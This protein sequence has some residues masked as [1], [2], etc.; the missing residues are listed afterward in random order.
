[1]AFDKNTL[2]R[3]VKLEYVNYYPTG[4]YISI[5]LLPTIDI[6]LTV[7]DTCI[8]AMLSGEGKIGEYSTLKVALDCA[9]K[10]AI[11][12]YWCNFIINHEHMVRCCKNERI[13]IMS[14]EEYRSSITAPLIIQEKYNE[15]FQLL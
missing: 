3:L 1:M 9:F 13:R 4:N 7:K 10:Y 5:I 14:I 15:I 8:I 6:E 11:D 12:I 2:V